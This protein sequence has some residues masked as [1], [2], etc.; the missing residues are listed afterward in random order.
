MWTRN[1]EGDRQ[2]TYPARQHLDGVVGAD[3]GDVEVSTGAT[4]KT[5]SSTR[6]STQMVGA[7]G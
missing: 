4:S 6:C 3:R 1:G 5:T 7:D 2:A